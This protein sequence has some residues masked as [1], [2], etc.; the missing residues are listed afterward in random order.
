MK[1]DPG[2]LV[3]IFFVIKARCYTLRIYHKLIISDP[4]HPR[5]MKCFVLILIN[6][7]HL[8]HPRAIESNFRIFIG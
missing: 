6:H 2:Y 5:A 4:R 7:N 8:R 1:I 3:G